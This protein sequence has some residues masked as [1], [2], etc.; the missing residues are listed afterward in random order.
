VAEAYVNPTVSQLAR[1][2]CTR[3]V[4]ALLDACGEPVDNNAVS[5]RRL[6]EDREACATEL[7]QSPEALAY[8]QNFTAHPD[9]VSRVF[10]EMKRCIERKGW[11]PLNTQPQQVRE[12][13]TSAFTPA[14]HPVP[15]ADLRATGTAVRG[16]EESL[17]GMPSAT[18]SVS[19][20]FLIVQPN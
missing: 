10:V 1:R 15:R 13:G 8:H 20:A 2:I 4:L 5:P 18:V 16:V 14:G 7:E 12:P 9:S 3:W 6:L 19:C 17:A 11:K